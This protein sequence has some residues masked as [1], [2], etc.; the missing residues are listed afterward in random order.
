MDFDR[1]MIELEKHIDDLI[2][3]VASQPQNEKTENMKKQIGDL[4]NRKYT[5]L[6]PYRFM[7]MQ[8]GIE[9]RRAA[10][11]AGYYFRDNY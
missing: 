4:F 6:D 2:L 9:N 7:E 1:K 10:E 8:G 5:V 11:R 3:Y